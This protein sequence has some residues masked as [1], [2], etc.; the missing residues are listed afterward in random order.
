MKKPFLFF[1]F[2]TFSACMENNQ[3]K[4]NDIDESNNEAL[5]TSDFDYL[6][7][8]TTNSVYNHSAYVFSY[9][10]IHEQS[11]W[12]AYYLDNNDINSVN[13]KRPFFEQDP[14]VETESADWRNYKNSGYDKGHL[15][16]A[17]DRKGSFDEYNETFFTSNISPQNHKFNSGIWNRLEE[18][19]RYWATKCNGLYVVTGGVLS[20]DLKTIGKE[21][22]SATNSCYNRKTNRQSN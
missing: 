10:E 19:T 12:V 13:F 4:N 1:L 15:C 18:K 11:E 2:L 16:P 20:D 7:T 6:P 22:S 3:I 5:L 17:A 14:I 8:S 9:S 21:N